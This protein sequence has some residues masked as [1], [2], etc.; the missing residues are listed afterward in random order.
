MVKDLELEKDIVG[1]SL[2]LSFITYGAGQLVSGYMGDRIAPRYLITAG[3]AVTAICNILVG[4]SRSISAIYVIWA[5]NGLAQSFMWPPLVKALTDN[6]DKESYAKANSCVITASQVA[7]VVVYGL[8]GLCASYSSWSSVFIICGG[9]AAAVC[10]VWFAGTGD[11][12]FSAKARTDNT[13]D[14][15]NTRLSVGALII[16]AGLIPILIAIVMQGMLKDGVTTWVPSYITETFNLPTSLSILTSAILPVFAIFSVIV[17]HKIGRRC[18]TEVHTTIWLWIASIVCAL[19]L[20][21]FH[22]WQMLIS[23]LLMAL[24]TACAHG[25]NLMLICNLPARFV[26]YGNVSFASGLLNSCTYIG[27]ALSTYGIAYVSEK[28]G[29]STTIIMWCVIAVIGL[30]T[31]IWAARRSE[32]VK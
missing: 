12:R 23:V 30:V 1:F 22:K 27:S 7:T 13:T 17:T 10:V 21:V 32:I 4:A 2:T 16:Q 20:L 28:L 15:K 19:G 5:V 8:A 9:L 31:C 26:K 25:I 18:K 24:M 29:W 11:I 6:M 14:C 3:L